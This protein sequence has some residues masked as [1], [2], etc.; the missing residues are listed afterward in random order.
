MACYSQAIFGSPQQKQAGGIDCVLAS[1]ASD[2]GDPDYQLRP[3]Y[4]AAAWSPAGAN[5]GFYSNPALD[6]LVDSRRRGA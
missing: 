4:E 2:N 1:W 3:L 6:A 5:L